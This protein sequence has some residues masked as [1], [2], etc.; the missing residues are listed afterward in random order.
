MANLHDNLK[1]NMAAIVNK[2]Y[3]CKGMRKTWLPTTWTSNAQNLFAICDSIKSDLGD[4]M[5]SLEYAS[6][7]IINYEVV[8][9]FRVS[10]ILNETF[11]VIS[12]VL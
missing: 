8:Y 2:A 11:S 1:T 12:N 4:L 5:E 7:C 9:L 10:S 3:Y 6:T